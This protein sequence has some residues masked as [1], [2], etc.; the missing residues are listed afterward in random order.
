ML[1][2]VLHASRVPFIAPRQLG[3]VGDLIGKQFL[4]SV[5]WRTGHEQ[6][7]SGTRSPSLSGAPER[8]TFGS[9]GTPDSP[10]WPTDHWRR[11]RVARRL[12]CRPLAACA[13]DSPD[14]PVIFSCG[15]FAF[16]RA[17]RVRRWSR[18]GTAHWRGHHGT[19]RCTTGCCWFGWTQPVFL[20]FN[21]FWL[22]KILGT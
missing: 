4:P 11:P 9:V 22:G 8:W 21:F 20:Q 3:V 1:G 19:V 5:G 12:R 14:S 17:W 15:A 10:V 16:S 13:V 7:M 18:W 6:Y 2:V